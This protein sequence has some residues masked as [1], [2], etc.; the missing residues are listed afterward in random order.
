MKIESLLNLLEG[1]D[2]NSELVVEIAKENG[3]KTTIYG[4]GFGNSEFGEF[5]LKVHE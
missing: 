3:E 1:L 4:V 5:M 2:P